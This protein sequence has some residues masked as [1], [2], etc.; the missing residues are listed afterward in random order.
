MEQVPCPHC[1]AALQPYDRRNRKCR[2]I[3]GDL[4][5]LVIRR[6][7]CCNPHCRHIHAELPDFLVPY[8]RYTADVIEAVLT[9]TA[10]VAPTEETTRRRWRIW[11]LQIQ[12]HFLGAM[13]S[14]RRILQETARTLLAS[15][16]KKSSFEVPLL[17]GLSLTEMVRLT[18]NSGN[19][20][21]TRSV[22]VSG[23][24]AL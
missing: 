8:K 11:Y 6:L 3:N 13:S 24:L 18:V 2:D 12:N 10:A 21:T 4:T 23:P 20:I 15:P 7:R 14:V 17:T 19:W 9:G 5:T 1:Q 16:S 22:M